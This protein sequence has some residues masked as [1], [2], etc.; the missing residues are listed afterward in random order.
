[1]QLMLVS[2]M[3]SRPESGAATKTVPYGSGWMIIVKL[4]NST[5]GKYIVFEGPILYSGTEITPDFPVVGMQQLT[6]LLVSHRQ[7]LVSH[8]QRLVS[9]LSRT[10]LPPVH[11]SLQSHPHHLPWTASDGW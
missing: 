3:K 1:M 7:R 9:P 2:G 10:Q 11:D 6:A 4:K 5:L 8:H